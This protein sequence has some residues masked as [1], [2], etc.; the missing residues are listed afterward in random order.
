M[1]DILINS[2]RSLL[3]NPTFAILIQ[4]QAV[5][6][7][8][9]TVLQKSQMTRSPFQLLAL[10]IMWLLATKGSKKGIVK[11]INENVHSALGAS[12]N[13]TVSDLDNLTNQLDW[14]KLAVELNASPTSFFKILLPKQVFRN[15]KIPQ[16]PT[17]FLNAIIK[18][19]SSD[20][21]EI[22]T[23]INQHFKWVDKLSNHDEHW[24][25]PSSTFTLS[26]GLLAALEKIKPQVPQEEKKS[27]DFTIGTFNIK[28]YR[29]KTYSKTPVEDAYGVKIFNAALTEFR[30]E[31]PKDSLINSGLYS[32]FVGATL[33][34]ELPVLAIAVK[35]AGES[36][37]NQYG[38][39]VEQ[40]QK[41]L[42]SGCC[43]RESIKEEQ[44]YFYFD[45]VV[46]S[47]HALFAN[48]LI[49]INYSQPNQQITLSKENVDRDVFITLFGVPVT[50]GK[51]LSNDDLKFCRSM[52]QQS[53][54]VVELHTHPLSHCSVLNIPAPIK[55]IN[56]TIPNEDMPIISPSNPDAS[57]AILKK[58]GNSTP[59][60]TS[61][62]HLQFI[63]QLFF[64]CKPK[65]VEP[66]DTNNVQ[67]GMN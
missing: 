60:P 50:P 2:L 44:Y 40:T 42:A 35:L 3:V 49:A 13:I 54:D 27:A 52:H 10:P 41:I 1:G 37:F 63:K 48:S 20:Q 30:A 11:R 19:G 16:I 57:N 8:K 62:S 58:S 33:Q 26:K 25:V 5:L 9:D 23:T 14:K 32:A 45:I 24:S 61:S 36:Y 43:G 29:C 67:N 4:A 56:T 31:L 59:L 6:D 64:C 47:T 51:A 53:I 17:E 21:I 39:G 65:Q 22:S 34:G 18:E 66:L 7:D 38:V 55:L 15:V 46:T 12:K 28:A